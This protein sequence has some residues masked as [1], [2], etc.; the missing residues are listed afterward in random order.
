[1]RGKDLPGARCQPRL[2]VT[3]FA[4]AWRPAGQVTH[5]SRRPSER[6]G[7]AGRGDEVVVQYEKVQAQ[8][9]EGIYGLRGRVDDRFAWPVARGVHQHWGE[10]GFLQLPEDAFQCGCCARWQALRPGGRVHVGRCGHDL[11]PVRGDYRRAR[12]VESPAALARPQPRRVIRKGNRGERPPGLTAFERVDSVANAG[13]AGNRAELAFLG[14]L[15]V[16]EAPA[17]T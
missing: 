9:L 12:H 14:T 1:M 15:E 8:V 7:S 16:L 11:L 3:G 13:W 10:A 6:A 5:W 2:P 4:I 17:K